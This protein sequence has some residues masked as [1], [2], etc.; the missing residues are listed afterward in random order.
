M[1]NFE[2]DGEIYSDMYGNSINKL[3][4][5]IEVL[6]YNIKTCIFLMIT[7]TLILLVISMTQIHNS[8]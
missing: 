5:K 7:N 3:I 8:V 2:M 4:E 6:E 1:N